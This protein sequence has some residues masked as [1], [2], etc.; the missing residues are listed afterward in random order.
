M[1]APG[2]HRDPPPQH[3]RAPTGEAG[4][5]DAVVAVDAVLAHAVDAGVA[6]TV[7]GVHLTV[8]T[9]HPRVARPQHPPHDRAPRGAG[10][11]TPG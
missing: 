5:A 3:P 7:V 9:W 4:L 6:G 2:G 10:W 1:G 11:A 8:D